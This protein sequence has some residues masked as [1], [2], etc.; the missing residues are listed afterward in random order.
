ME[1]LLQRC[2]RLCFYSQWFVSNCESWIAVWTDTAFII[3]IDGQHFFHIVA[4]QHLTFLQSHLLTCILQDGHKRLVLS[5]FTFFLS[6]SSF[7]QLCFLLI[8]Q[9]DSINISSLTTVTNLLFSHFSKA[10]CSINQS[11]NSKATWNSW[12]L[13]W[14]I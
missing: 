12:Y 6:L 4:L 14:F 8:C 9:R 5:I 3:D 13:K 7:G 10:F 1:E 2:S 11:K